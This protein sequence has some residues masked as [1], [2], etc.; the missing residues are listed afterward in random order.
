M[1]FVWSRRFAIILMRIIRT[2]ILKRN[3]N[4]SWLS[5]YIRAFN[6]NAISF[7]YLQI[8]GADGSLL[9]AESRRGRGKGRGGGAVSN[10]F[11]LQ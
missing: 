6:N 3:V 7:I 1:V 8:Y 5:H 4:L 11:Y 9:R 10:R 2:N